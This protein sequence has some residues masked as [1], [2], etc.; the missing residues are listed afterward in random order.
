MRGALVALA[1][2]VALVVSTGAIADPRGGWGRGWGHH[3]G[4]HWRPSNPATSFWGG[5]L[6]GWIGSQF[7][8]N[9]D[10]EEEIDEIEPW[11]KTWFA[12]C[13]KRYRS[14]DP[15]TGTFLS[16]DGERRFCK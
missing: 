15:E 16:F 11:S 14:F 2:A 6:G 10:D 12:Y 1:L 4:H 3:G 8:R 9:R 13:T 7:N 5:V